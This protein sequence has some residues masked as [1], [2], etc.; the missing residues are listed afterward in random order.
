MLVDRA[1]DPSDVVRRVAA[2]LDRY[3]HPLTGGDAGQGWPFGG[4]IRYVPLVQRVLA[5][6]DV[7][8][9]DR[10]DFLVDGV[11][12]APCSDRALPPNSLLWP[13]AHE[14]AA[15]LERVS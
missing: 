10:L 15:E 7:R 4:P 11:R 9:V 12:V 1:A 13:D 3:L 14:V 5:V 2:A 6:G 8:A